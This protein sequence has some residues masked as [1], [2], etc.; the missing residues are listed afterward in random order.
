MSCPE[1]VRLEKVHD[2]AVSVFDS[3]R[4][5]LRARIGV[6]QRDEFEQL[7]RAVD[8]AWSALQVVRSEL[9]SHIRTHGCEAA[10]SVASSLE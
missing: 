1:R 3:V 6:S 4:A 9:D 8:E 5:Q 7:N 2:D 10:S